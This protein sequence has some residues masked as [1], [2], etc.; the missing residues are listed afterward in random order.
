MEVLCT[1][2]HTIHC[3]PIDFLCNDWMTVDKAIKSK[4]VT[5]GEGRREALEEDSLGEY[6]TFF[7]ELIEIVN[8][9]SKE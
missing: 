8:K 1:S 4:R 2:L 3:T 6:S 7:A 9:C 5:D